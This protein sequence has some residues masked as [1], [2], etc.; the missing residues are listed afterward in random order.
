MT[1]RALICSKSL[2]GTAHSDWW[3]KWWSNCLETEKE[4]HLNSEVFLYNVISYLKTNGWKTMVQ[5]E[6]EV[7]EGE[8]LNV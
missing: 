6:N 8:L 2:A 7:R 1:E 4:K 3:R 5:Q